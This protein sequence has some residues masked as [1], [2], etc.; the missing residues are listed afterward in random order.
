MN[1]FGICNDQMST[2]NDKSVSLDNVA[3]NFDNLQ[4]TAIKS[5]IQRVP[6]EPDEVTSHPCDFKITNVL[7]E[8]KKSISDLNCKMTSLEN[9]FISSLKYDAS[10]EVLIDQLH[11]E[12]QIYKD[13]LVAKLHEPLLKELIYLY[14]DFVQM[15]VLLKSKQSNQIEE[16]TIETI[17]GFGQNILLVLEKYDVL[18]FRNDS[19]QFDP[20]VQ[21]AVNVVITND[22][23]KNKLVKNSLR[24]GF[25]NNTRIIRPESVEVYRYKAL[26]PTIT[27][28]DD[29]GILNN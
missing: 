28:T 26:A 16:D 24:A 29:S 25:R 14:D 23:D 5:N 12:L 6:D 1:E 18:Q 9:H 10:K 17:D 7:E 13:D 11:K 19:D 4:T 8:F 22:I 27:D 20:K 21:Q 2:T 15:L 3:P